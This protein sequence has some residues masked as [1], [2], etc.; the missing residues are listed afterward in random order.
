MSSF[1]VVT[2][3]YKNIFNPDNYEVYWYYQIDKDEELIQISY[4][5]TFD[6]D[7]F[8]PVLE[9]AKETLI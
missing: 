9:S 1:H 6:H 3:K 8:H 4:D 7:L 2:E 5:M